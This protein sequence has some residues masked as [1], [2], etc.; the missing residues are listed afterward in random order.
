MVAKIKLSTG[1]DI[2]LTKKKFETKSCD[3][4]DMFGVCMCVCAT[5]RELKKKA[6]VLSEAA[7][8][9]LAAGIFDAGNQ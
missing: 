3:N 4:C 1:R 6:R 2:T 8:P 5:E 7:K 9:S